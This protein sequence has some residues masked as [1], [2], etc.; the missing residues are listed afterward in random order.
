MQL[1]E[2]IDNHYEGGDVYSD[3]PNINFTCVEQGDEVLDGKVAYQSS[4]YRLDGTNDYFEVT[5]SW[6]NSWYW[7]DSE[8][9]DPESRKVKPITKMVQVTE[10]R[11]AD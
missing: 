11:D 8:R 7:S 3:D 4:V 5:E 2:F 10:W 6:S 9:F 1:Q